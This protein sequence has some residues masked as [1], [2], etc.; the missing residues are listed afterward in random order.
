M[1]RPRRGWGGVERR[2]G[3]RRKVLRDRERWLTLR[4]VRQFFQGYFR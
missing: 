3:R 2:G 4:T 1:W